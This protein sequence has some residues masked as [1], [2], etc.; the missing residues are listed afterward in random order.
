MVLVETHEQEIIIIKK[1]HKQ[2]DKFDLYLFTFFLLECLEME[3][4]K[5][6]I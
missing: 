3:S 2:R 5:V 4:N 1:K 6:E